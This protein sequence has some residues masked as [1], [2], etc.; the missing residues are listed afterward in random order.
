M[1]DG[2]YTIHTNF[3]DYTDLRRSVRSGG[4]RKRADSGTKKFRFPAK[5]MSDTTR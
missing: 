4:H 5:L 1:Y 3:Y 2:L